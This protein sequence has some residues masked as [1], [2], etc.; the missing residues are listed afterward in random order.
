MHCGFLVYH[1]LAPE[2]AVIRITMNS[3]RP[4]RSMLWMD[5][6]AKRIVA[7]KAL[8]CRHKPGFHMFMEIL[9]YD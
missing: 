8:F 3:L 2:S 4:D 1:C 6:S 5:G 7:E 9:L